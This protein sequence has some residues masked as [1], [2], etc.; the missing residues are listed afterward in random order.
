MCV[1]RCMDIF[2]KMPVIQEMFLC[3]KIICHLFLAFK[4]V[5]SYP[6]YLVVSLKT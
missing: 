5:V 2:V 6:K 3:S 4:K 1:G